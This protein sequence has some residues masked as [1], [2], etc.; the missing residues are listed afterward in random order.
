MLSISAG[1]IRFV[2]VV[3]ESFAS[4]ISRKPYDIPNA[5][6]HTQKII[7]KPKGVGTE[8]KNLADGVTGVMLRLEYK[9]RKVTWQIKIGQLSLLAQHGCFGCVSPTLEA[10]V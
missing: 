10:I 5:L 3:D 4:W 7:R 6:P 9:K 2:L 1:L 8:L